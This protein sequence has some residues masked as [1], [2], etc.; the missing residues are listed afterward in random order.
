MDSSMHRVDTP[1]FSGQEIRH[2]P[3]SPSSAPSTVNLAPTHRHKP[4]QF[5]DQNLPSSSDNH[6]QNHS[7]GNPKHG[8]NSS[9][10]KKSPIPE[11][12]T[13]LPRHPPPFVFLGPRYPTIFYPK[14]LMFPPPGEMPLRFPPGVLLPRTQ[15]PRVYNPRL[16]T[17]P[18]QPTDFRHHYRPRHQQPIRVPTLMTSSRNQRPV[19]YRMPIQTQHQRPLQASQHHSN[20][21]QY[22]RHG[23][24]SAMDVAAVSR[25]DFKHSRQTVFKEELGTGST[26]PDT[27]LRSCSPVPVIRRICPNPGQNFPS[28]SKSGIVDINE[29]LFMENNETELSR[30]KNG[31]QFHLIKTGQ[32]L[33]RMCF[34]VEVGCQTDM[35]FSLDK[36]IVVMPVEALSDMITVAEDERTKNKQDQSEED[37]EPGSLGT[38]IA[39]TTDDENINEETDEGDFM[40]GPDISH[41]EFPESSHANDTLKRNVLLGENVKNCFQDLNNIAKESFE[42][43][44]SYASSELSPTRES[45][46]MSPIK[47]SL[48]M[49]PVKE[50]SEL[51]PIK[52][53]LE[54]S[55]TR[56][57]YDQIPQEEQIK[58]QSSRSPKSDFNVKKS[59]KENISPGKLQ[60]YNNYKTIEA[61]TKLN[62]LCNDS[63]SPNNEREESFNPLANFTTLMSYTNPLIETEWAEL[64][65]DE[66]TS[67]GVGFPQHYDQLARSLTDCSIRSI[68][69]TKGG[70]ENTTNNF[71][72]IEKTAVTSNQTKKGST[73]V[74]RSS[75]SIICRNPG[76]VKVTSP[77]KTNSTE[78]SPKLMKNGDITECPDITGGIFSN[79]EDQEPSTS[80]KQC[81]IRLSQSNEKL[82]QENPRQ[83]FKVNEN[84]KPDVATRMS[85]EQHSKLDNTSTKQKPWTFCEDISKNWNMSFLNAMNTSEMCGSVTGIT[86][87]KTDETQHKPMQKKLNK[88]E[89]TY[90]PPKETQNYIPPNEEESYTSPKEAEK[91]TS[92]KEAEKYTPPKKTEKC[93]S[94]KKTEKCTSL[95][96]E[97]YITQ[98]QVDKYNSPKEEEKYIPL[99][100]ADNYTPPK[101]LQEDVVKD[102]ENE[103]SR[104]SVKSLEMRSSRGRIL[105]KKRFDDYE[106]STGESD[107]DEYNYHDDS[108]E[109]SNENSKY[110]FCA[111]EKQNKQ[112]C[113]GNM[114]GPIKI[115]SNGPVVSL[116][117][118]TT[119]KDTNENHIS[120][121]IR[122]AA[123][124]FN[125]SIPT[126]SSNLHDLSAESLV[127]KIVSE[128]EF[129]NSVMDIGETKLLKETQLLC[130]GE[131]N[132]TSKIEEN[133]DISPLLHTKL[134]ENDLIADISNTEFEMKVYM[135]SSKSEDNSSLPLNVSVTPEVPEITDIVKAK[136]KCDGGDRILRSASKA[137]F[138]LIPI[139]D[140]ETK[141]NGA[142]IKEQGKKKTFLKN[143]NLPNHSREKLNT[144]YSQ[145][146]KELHKVFVEVMKDPVS[147]EFYYTINDPL[148][149]PRYYMINNLEIDLKSVEMKLEHNIY[150]NTE[151]FLEDFRT[152]AKT[153]EDYFGPMHTVSKNSGKL[154]DLVCGLI[155][156]LH[157][158]ICNRP[159]RGKKRNNI[160]ADD[161]T[162]KKSRDES[163]DYVCEE[164]G[165]IFV[166]MRSYNQHLKTKTG[167]AKSSNMD[168][169]MISHEKEKDNSFQNENADSKNFDGC[170]PDVSP[171]H[172][173]PPSATSSLK[174]LSKRKGRP[175]K[176]SVFPQPA[177]HG[178]AVSH[179]QENIVIDCLSNTKTGGINSASA[180]RKYQCDICGKKFTRPQHMKR[181]RLL[182]TGERPHPCP[183][184]HKSFAREDKL[185]IHMRACSGNW[186]SPWTGP[187]PKLDHSLDSCELEVDGCTTGIE[188]G[189]RL[190]EGLEA[191]ITA[192]TS[193]HSKMDRVEQTSKNK[194]KK[195]HL[196][197]S[198]E[199]ALDNHIDQDNR[200]AEFF[201]KENST[202][203][204]SLNHPLPL[205]ATSS[206]KPLSKRKGR[207]KKSAVLVQ[208]AVHGVAVS[209]PQDNIVIDADDDNFEPPG[210]LVRSPVDVIANNNIM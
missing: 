49:S 210:L 165:I 23:E 67:S 5:T 3:G 190:D 30:S 203:E 38:E 143:E 24:M 199:E 29:N 206:L 28:T 194:R 141:E 72:C 202:G 126:T 62:E 186:T 156:C 136:E 173:P 169:R 106:E 135:D 118:S 111:T 33:A 195:C 7:I 86:S 205:T 97:K 110:F 116:N 78:L 36:E 95:K 82:E 105:K 171:N 175:K 85:F 185:K 44:H 35:S 54:M 80:K 84:K 138:K 163:P 1:G 83:K 189:L 114:D 2:P 90:T 91:Y 14:K 13:S 99:K 164:C 131:V 27:D 123:N 108:E 150:K 172:P 9:T 112:P 145:L 155:S 26:I 191:E 98:N 68:Q 142:V 71:E 87:L 149:M 58:T 113:I 192:G 207:P 42:E 157:K 134:C 107:S 144:K 187:I 45:S 121:A 117:K 182:H 183:T 188:I 18:Q 70:Q 59:L 96:E 198:S 69:E 109:Y 20:K 100:E 76:Y 64:P 73:D 6:Q 128:G 170:N 153:S 32:E 174:P 55:P 63:F 132:E 139:K 40:F 8:F 180:H 162:S 94:P 61:S 151:Q 103:L 168:N 31:D 39:S 34:A 159:S 204:D 15:P 22:Y 166:N 179:S 57:S 75:R 158:E 56:E 74:S 4:H 120:I 130:T 129:E 167:C 93:T 19:S 37:L 196:Q 16:P 125:A 122:D 53:S 193:Q 102:F 137:N 17:H 88:K 161:N 48:E 119:N 146:T 60:T 50:S 115:E 124:I 176:S 184:C 148:P 101:K 47:E 79:Y 92:P 200:C 89:E 140:M 177:V 181:H 201:S 152:I 51:S 160:E 66:S 43:D 41:D 197:F 133:L 209:H 154:L 12:Q 77:K 208:P 65:Y 25:L 10:P 52:E 21:S 46:E 104:K 11:D 127:T 147:V 81:F 178:V